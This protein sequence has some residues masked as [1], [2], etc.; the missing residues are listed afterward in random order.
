VELAKDGGGWLC[1][2]DR[3]NNKLEH[4]PGCLGGLEVE[5][6]KGRMENIDGELVP[7]ALCDFLLWMR[8]VAEATSSLAPSF[9]WI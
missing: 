8:I 7:T 5:K 9:S 3:I 2:N 4:V 6:S 1:H